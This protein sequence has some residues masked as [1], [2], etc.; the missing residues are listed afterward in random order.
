VP[1]CW[2]RWW[3]FSSGADEVCELRCRER[4]PARVGMMLPRVAPL[5]GLGI[6]S[7][8]HLLQHRCQRPLLL[9]RRM[10]TVSDAELTAVT[11][12]HD[13]ATPLVGLSDEEIE[14]V[15]Q[16]VGGLHEEAGPFVGNIFDVTFDRGQFRIDQ[17]LSAEKYAGPRRRPPVVKILNHVASTTM[18][19][20]RHSSV[21]TTHK[22]I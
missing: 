6:R 4:R 10:G 18:A 12:R 2:G 11:P 19:T 22:C 17:N 16:R 7:A 14:L 21:K 15:G 8:Q 5:P 1:L 20:V 13:G 3:R 9:A